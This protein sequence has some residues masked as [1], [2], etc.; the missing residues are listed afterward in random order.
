MLRKNVNKIKNILNKYFYILYY[1]QASK[2][3]KKK[4]I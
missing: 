1:L 4:S 2:P 3:K